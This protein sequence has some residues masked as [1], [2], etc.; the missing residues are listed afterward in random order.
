MK[1]L[2]LFFKYSKRGILLLTA[3]EWY[4]IQ[5]I[6]E[7]CEVQIHPKYYDMQCTEYRKI[8]SNITQGEVE[9]AVFENFVMSEEKIRP[10]L[11]RFNLGRDVLLNNTRYCVFIVPLHVELYIQEFLPNL[12]SY[13]EFKEQY[14]NQYTNYCDFIFPEDGY[15]KTKDMQRVLKSNLKNAGDDMVQQ[16]EGN[17][18]IRISKE[19]FLELKKNVNQ[20]VELIQKNEKNI[21]EKIQRTNDV[22]CCRLLTSLARVA[23]VQGYYEEAIDIYKEFIHKQKLNSKNIAFEIWYG[24]ADTYLYAEE[25]DEAYGTYAQ[26][27]KWVMNQYEDE[28][29]EEHFLNEK[30]RLYSKLAL[31]EFKRKNDEKALQYIKYT[32]MNIDE[33]NAEQKK[34]L[35]PVYYNYLLMWLDIFPYRTTEGDKLLE[36]LENF[37]KNEMQKGMF[38]T[39]KAWY[40]GIINGDLYEAEKEAM[41]ALNIKRRLCMENDVRIAESHYINA[42]LKMFQ[43]DYDKALYCCNKSSNIL[44][45]VAMHEEQKEK[46]ESVVKIIAEKQRGFSVCVK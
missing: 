23:T 37:D 12:Y 28:I 27:L 14:L 3:N 31:C 1:K 13:F 4:Q 36:C 24:L 5:Q 15:L 46:R 42:M 6:K 35:F 39:V 7:I 22:F 45:N 30:V 29:A 44:K 20:Y 38:L 32:F 18:H 26:I 43:G 21:S 40:R 25:Y 11:E 34:S 19:Q 8:L 10:L 17:L 16:L 9:S 33:L 2:E 41:E